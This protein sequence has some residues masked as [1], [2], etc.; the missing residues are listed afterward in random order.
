[1]LIAVLLLGFVSAMVAVMTTAILSSTNAMAETAQAEVLGSEIL[2]NL[3]R[4]LRFGH[5]ISVLKETKED[6]TLKTEEVPEGIEGVRVTYLRSADDE[7]TRYTLYLGTE[8]D[9]HPGKIVA[10][11]Y[12]KGFESR[13]LLFGGVSYGENLSVSELKFK[14]EDKKVTISIQIVY[15][16]NELYNGNI[17]VSPLNAFKEETKSEET[18]S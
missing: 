9:G 17:S 12:E 8:A 11:Y 16:E 2:E 14:K 6:G 4:E 13:D 3:A 18:Q 5:N 15:G 7:H 10:Q 1:M